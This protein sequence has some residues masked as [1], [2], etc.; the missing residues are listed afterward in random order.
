MNT[1]YGKIN[2]MEEYKKHPTSFENNSIL[3]L[4]EYL[5]S[6]FKDIDVNST[7]MELAVAMNW[8]NKFQQD[9]DTRKKFAPNWQNALKLWIDDIENRISENNFNLIDTE[10]YNRNFCLIA[11]I[12]NKVSGGIIEPISNYDTYLTYD[13][14]SKKNAFCFQIY[15]YLFDAIME[16]VIYAFKL[17]TLK[18]EYLNILIAKNNNKTDTLQHHNALPIKW[19]KNSVLLAYLI[20]ELK[21]SGFIADDNIW[22]ICEQIFVDKSGKPI[23]A[24][25]FTSMVKKL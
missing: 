1:Y 11:T 4:N 22:S 9:Y 25:T 14:G 18:D 23:K 6:N 12:F 2:L 10:Y 7:I 21:R 5:K 16:G 20:N 3:T 13:N 15:T 17:T 19:L 24:E 8:E